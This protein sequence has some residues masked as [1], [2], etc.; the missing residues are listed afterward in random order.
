VDM[1]VSPA[2]FSPVLMH[3]SAPRSDPGVNDKMIH[4]LPKLPSTTISLDEPFCQK[5][6]QTPS[7]TGAL[8]VHPGSVIML[9][10]QENGHIT[11]P[12]LS[13]GKNSSGLVQVYGILSSTT[14][15]NF[16]PVVN[17]Y[18]NGTTAKKGTGALVLP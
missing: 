10:Y 15:D 18:N 8:Q 14:P 3:V 1:V 11:M 16:Y 2:P 12:W 17:N 5:S 4:R 6:Q 13:P 7:K 9:R